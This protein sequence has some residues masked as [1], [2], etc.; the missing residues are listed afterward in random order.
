MPDKSATSLFLAPDTTPDL[1]LYSALIA[2]GFRR[3]G[4]YIYRPR[5]DDCHA[6]TPL[7]IP[8]MTYRQ[9]RADRRISRINQDLTCREVAPKITDEHFDL[10]R[11]YITDRHPEGGM[12]SLTQPQLQ[13]FLLSPWWTTRLIEFRKASRIVALSALD[14]LPDTLSAVYSIYDPASSKRSLGSLAIL[15][16]IELARIDSLK[17]LYL[18]YWISECRKMSYKSKFRPFEYY[19][20]GE[21]HPD[22]TLTLT[23]DPHLQTGL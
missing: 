7:R 1:L 4:Q 9:R 23:S 21:W 12:V 5:C 8:I 3:S 13:E 19:R 2:Q 17:W 16:A 20:N 22:C 18:G 6:C 15:H 14:Q 11:R 10:Y